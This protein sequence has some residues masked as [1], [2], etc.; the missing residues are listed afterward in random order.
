M[1]YAITDIE[2]TGESTARGG[3]TEICI[4]VTDGQKVT[5]KFSSLINPM[6]AI[7]PSVVSLTGITDSMVSQAP[8]FAEIAE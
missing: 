1:Q 3:I 6:R 4:Y 5:K 8:T 7:N 2:T